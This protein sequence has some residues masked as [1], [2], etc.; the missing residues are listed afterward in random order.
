MQDGADNGRVLPSDTPLVTVIVPARNEEASIRA[1]LDS[2]LHQ[3]VPLEDVQIIVA[4]GGSDDR[5]AAVARCMLETSGI[6]DWVVIED[7]SGDTPSNLNAGLAHARGM[8]VARVDARSRIPVDYLATCSM[9]LERRADVAVV[10]GRQHA[11]AETTSATTAVGIKRSLN[12]PISTGW[13]R[14]RRSGTSGPADTVYLGFFRRC[15]LVELG[16][17]DPR[18]LTNQDFDLNRRLSARG[19]VWYEASLLVDYVPRT[20][21]RD[22]AVQY[23]R[24]GRWK[25][26]YWR[27]T[28]D[29]PRLRQLALLSGGVLILILGPFVMVRM[30]RQRSGWLLLCATGL[31]MVAAE[32]HG[33][34]EADPLIAS[35]ASIGASGVVGISWLAGIARELVAR[36]AD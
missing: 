29:R 18:L 8:F 20:S 16:G 36:S 11:I 31:G 32:R 24:F 28:R 22:L 35:V 26:R 23:H 25:V 27:T 17:W 5:T 33:D 21:F 12:N 6:G 19:D 15:D 13:A 14:Y 9:I 34:D 30:L 7:T 1:C 3:T 4:A 2:I 10:G